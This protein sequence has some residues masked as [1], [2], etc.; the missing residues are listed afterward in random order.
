MALGIGGLEFEE[1]EPLFPSRDQAV[2][3]E[4]GTYAGGGQGKSSD[5][6]GDFDADPGTGTGLFEYLQRPGTQVYVG[7]DE[8]EIESGKLL[9]VDSRYIFCP[10][11][12]TGNVRGGKGQVQKSLGEEKCFR[13]R[14]E[15]GVAEAGKT[16]K[17]ADDL[18]IT[19]ECEVQLVFLQKVYELV[20]TV[21][22][23]KNS[24][25]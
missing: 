6:L 9:K 12:A 21:V 13:Y 8:D 15:D 5:Q 11:A 20:G 4:G 24:F 3:D 7:I 2:T 10:V 1:A 14:Q 16:F 23:D 22:N 17:R 25:I 19:A 18:F